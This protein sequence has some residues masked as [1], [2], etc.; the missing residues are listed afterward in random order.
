MNFT[1]VPLLLGIA[2]IIGAV[3]LFFLDRLRPGYGRDSDKVYAVLLLI[4][5]VILLSEWTMPLLSSLQ[6]SI[7]VGLLTSLL[8]QNINSRTPQPVR[9]GRGPETE[10]YGG[11]GG[12]RPS[13]PSR[14]A[15]SSDSRANLRAELDMRRP[16]TYDPYARP[17]P[18]LSGR[19]EPRPP[20]PPQ[21]SYSDRYHDGPPLPPPNGRP[22]GDVRPGGDA[23]SGGDV[24]PGGGPPLPP[25]DRSDGPPY[26]GSGSRPGDDRVR[27][28]RPSKSRDDLN[29]RYRLDPGPPRPDY[30]PGGRG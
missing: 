11:G 19:D 15:Y 5:G 8:I 26:Y 18:M 28:R 20:Y 10:P 12:Y 23:R 3:L 25:D 17:R 24:R 29:D 30:R 22:G 21:D 16:D 4:S 7:M 6:Q 9:P 2:T 14:P 1:P 13:R 27:R